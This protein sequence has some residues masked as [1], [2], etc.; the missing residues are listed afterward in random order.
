MRLLI[1]V[2]REISGQAFA[3]V[4]NSQYPCGMN[5]RRQPQRRVRRRPARISASAG[6]S[7]MES[8]GWLVSPAVFK[9]V[10]GP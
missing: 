8:D 2:I 4:E 9:T 10:V 3:W 6:G 7:F 5:K 1:R